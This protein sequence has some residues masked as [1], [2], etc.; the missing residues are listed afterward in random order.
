MRIG[1]CIN[2]SW[3]IYNFRSGLIRTLI[4]EGH[5]VVA[6]APR[7]E[8]SE[9]LV[10]KL[11][12]EYVSFS[13]E[14]TGS[15]P[16]NDFKVLL[17]LRRIYKQSNLDIVLQ[18]TIKPNIFGTL[19]AHSL[20]I[21][22]INNV[23]GLGTVFL[24]KS[25]SSY[26][27]KCLYRFSFKRAN[28]VFFQNPDDKVDFLNEIRI[29]NLKTD[30]LPGS[31][32]DLNRYQSTSINRSEPFTFLM[33]ARLIIDKG[34]YE[35]IEAARLVKKEYPNVIFQLL[36][37]LDEG[38][39]RGISQVVIE[40]AQEDGIVTYLGI[41]Q[42]VRQQIKQAHVVVLP[43]YREGTPKTLLEAS[44]LARPII[45][46]NVPGCREVV[47]EGKNG[48][49]CEVRDNHS[50]AAAMSRMLALTSSE[51]EQMGSY[52]RKKIELEYDEQIVIKKY[53][54]HITNIINAT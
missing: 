28:L 54:Y 17:A 7:D 20:G 12:C 27:A 42:D 43:S 16:I 26:V 40:S 50:L 23:S 1:I 18:Y 30:L 44:A 4:N 51:L 33:I 37:E 49:L 15:N 29:V 38:H 3:N 36:G 21:P 25:I 47:D 9:L 34:V 52:G 8:F 48:Y 35:Y 45:A 53:L 19:A 2:T 32:V 41:S 10:E 22:V 14:N 5:K 24:N 13:L 6:I 39:Q 11:R 46:S 31:G